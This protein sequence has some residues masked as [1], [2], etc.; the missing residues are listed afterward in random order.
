MATQPKPK[1]GNKEPHVTQKQ[2]SPGTAVAAPPSANQVPAHLVEAA[3]ED[4]GRGVST[5]RA[6]NI[7]P[8][9]YVMHPLSPQVDESSPQHVAGARPGSIWLRN[10]Q[11]PMVPGDQGILVQPC[12]FGKDWPEWVP[13]TSG[14][15][16]VARHPN[17]IATA[18]DVKKYG[19]KLVE[20]EDV[21]DCPDATFKV[22]QTNRQKVWSRPN[23]N[24]LILT[25]NH[26][27]RVILGE[28]QALQYMIPMKGASHAVSKEWMGKMMVKHAPDGT[29]LPS[30]SCLYRL[31]TRQRKNQKGTWYQFQVADAGYVTPEDYR[32]GRALNA[33][34]ESGEKVAEAEVHTGSGEDAP[35][36]GGKQGD[37]L[38]Y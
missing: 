11:T 6:D 10:W 1:N 22:D 37:D 2:E 31:T 13:R 24:N 18:E 19:D 23:G 20:G 21:P 4:A 34:V 38:P 28:G 3:K 9:I 7:I 26:A 29:L 16:F 25:R 30:F 36:G 32:A 5:D 27:V 35:A 17:K 33:A 12:A 8:L 15:G 14:G